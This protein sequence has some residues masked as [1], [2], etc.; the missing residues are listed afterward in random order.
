MS[1]I[2]RATAA[3]LA[4]SGA[5]A[6]QMSSM[7]ANGAS[8]GRLIKSQAQEGH[9]SRRSFAAGVFAL[10]FVG[11]MA[12]AANAVSET[13]RIAHRDAPPPRLPPP[14][15]PSNESPPAAAAA[16]AAATTCTP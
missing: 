1:R 5:S 4:M 10:P 8:T 2:L 14:P 3:A 7:N 16:S 6:Y 15:P 9:A 12:G 13:N 11:A